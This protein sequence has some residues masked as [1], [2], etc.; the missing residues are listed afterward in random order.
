MICICNSG[1]E[2]SE[3]CQPY[4]NI[5]GYSLNHNENILFN[6]MTRYGN[7]GEKN[8]LLKFRKYLNRIGNYADVIFSTYTPI[9]FEHDLSVDVNMFHSI[10]HN[11]LLTIFAATS[12]LSQGLF[13]QSGILLRSALEDC[14]VLV[15]ITVNKDQLI[16]FI[17]KKYQA[18]KSLTRVKKYLHKDLLIWYGYFSENFTH[19]G[20]LHTA[21]FLPTACHP[22]NWVTVTGFQNIVRVLVC[23]HI[24]SERIN[25]EN[26][27]KRYFWSIKNEDNSF[28]FNEDSKIY[29]WAEQIGK[30]III[31]YPVE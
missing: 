21:N 4:D 24:I 25:F 16:K 7:E 6:W 9:T 22:N 12:C 8:F 30:E 29:L 20:Q 15:D 26:V 3:C 11:I 18:N 28:V 27:T 2:Y 19:A 14:F 17:N 1:K 13:I 10:H 31:D 5:I 23:L